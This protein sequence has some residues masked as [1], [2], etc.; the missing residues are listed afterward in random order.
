[1]CE[2]SE[3]DTTEACPAREVSEK[4]PAP[5]IAE[6]DG[7]LATVPSAQEAPPELRHLEKVIPHRHA[8][9][10]LSTRRPIAAMARSTLDR[11]ERGRRTTARMNQAFI[12]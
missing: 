8:T 2:P 1:M 7:R 3:A 11:K 6:G 10:G 4:R 5:R 12:K 9:C